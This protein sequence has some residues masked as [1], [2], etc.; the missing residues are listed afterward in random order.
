MKFIAPKRVI[1]A[2]A[3]PRRRE[4]LQLLGLPFA[5]I[6]SDVSEDVGWKG[7]DFQ[8]LARALAAKKTWAVAAGHEEAIV[9][10][11]DTIVVQDGVVYPKPASEAEAIRFLRKLSGREHSVITG[12][13]IYHNGQVETF[14]TETIVTFRKL[15]DALIDAY[16]R[17]KDPMDKAGAYGIQTAGALLVAKIE[18]DYHTVVGLPIAKLVE[19]LRRLQLI[20]LQEGGQP[21]AD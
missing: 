20:V 15:D 16:V 12:V 13:G 19:E 17:S 4:L 1:L 21:N 2:S 18:G 6:P 7:D 3:S 5:V 9:I 14:A 10:G 11:A 8:G